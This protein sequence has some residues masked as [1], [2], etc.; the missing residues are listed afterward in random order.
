[1]TKANTYGKLLL[2]FCRIQVLLLQMVE[3][4]RINTEALLHTIIEMIKV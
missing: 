1:M 2:E 3:F 4:T